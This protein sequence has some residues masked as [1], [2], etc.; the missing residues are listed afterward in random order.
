MCIRDSYHLVSKYGYRPCYHLTAAV[1]HRNHRVYS[2]GIALTI[3][4][5]YRLHY[6]TIFFMTSI[7]PDIFSRVGHYHYSAYHSRLYHP[8]TRDQKILRDEARSAWKQ[9]LTH[10]LCDYFPDF[11]NRYRS[12]RIA[13]T[14]RMTFRGSISG[15]EV[16]RE[17]ACSCTEIR[18]GIIRGIFEL[19]SAETCSEYDYGW[20]FSGKCIQPIRQIKNI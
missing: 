14:Y 11:L 5:V 2:A 7:W 20:I 8:F 19:K 1:H 12:L 4:G 9:Y 6:L 3:A 15:R 18:M 13:R 10:Y 16:R 17:E